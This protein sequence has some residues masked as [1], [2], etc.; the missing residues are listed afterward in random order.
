[1][2][3]YAK[4]DAILREML[5]FSGPWGISACNRGGHTRGVLRNDD[6]NV[7]QYIIL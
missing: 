7:G 3:T 5:V 6:A 2:F 1:M 4:D